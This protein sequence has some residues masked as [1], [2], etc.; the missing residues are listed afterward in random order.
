MITVPLTIQ[1][2][3]RSQPEY[4]MGYQYGIARLAAGGTERGFILNG[5]TFA[6]RDELSNLSPFDLA[7]AEIEAISSKLVISEITLIPRPVDSL[8]GV[9]RIHTT[10]LGNSQK[11]AQFS[12]ANEAYRASHGAIDASI[13]NTKPGEVFCRFS[14]YAN[15]F[16]ITDKRALTAGTF[17]TTKEDAGF[18]KTGR[19]A[20][21]RYA[22][23]NKRSANK[24]YAITPQDNTELKEGIVQ[25]AYGEIGGGVEVIFVKGTTDGTVS[26]PE[27]LPE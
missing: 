15:D 7:K 20:I 22:L 4:A 27:L 25:P 26:L 19:D 23:E 13:T 2:R 16:R 14:A 10:F 8:K 11:S 3:L 18:V 12:A 21:S 6:T 9:R 1:Y 5:A 17:A 24:Q